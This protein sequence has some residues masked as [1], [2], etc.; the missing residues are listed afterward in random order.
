MSA[1]IY[2][3]QPQITESQ[4]Q[5]AA[6]KRRLTLSGKASSE[7]DVK[8]A[9][10]LR[11]AAA[12]AERDAKEQ[13]MAREDFLRRQAMEDALREAL[14]ERQKV[15]A[16]AAKIY[17]EEHIPVPPTVNKII[18]AVSHYYGVTPNDIKSHRKTKGILIPRMVVMYLARTMT[19]K[20]LSEISAQLGGRDHTTVLNGYQRICAL[21]KTNAE[22]SDSVDS[23]RLS[24]MD[25]L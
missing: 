7:L 6:L 18:L 11:H 10:G 8:S 21:M 16:I 25:K 12:A 14:A 2:T 22:L 20:S 24:L 19:I 3:Y 15:L 23:L 5:A 4:R 1:E 17:E 13:R 9:P